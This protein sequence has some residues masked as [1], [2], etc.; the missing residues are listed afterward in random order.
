MDAS[1]GTPVVLTPH[2]VPQA[3]PR[4]PAFHPPDSSTAANPVVAN[5]N[6]VNNTIVLLDD[7][8][9]DDDD[10]VVVHVKVTK[11]LKPSRT[12]A[13]CQSTQTDGV[14]TSTADVIPL[15][16]DVVPLPAG[17]AVAGHD[18]K[19]KEEDDRQYKCPV[20]LESFSAVSFELSVSWSVI[21]EE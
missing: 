18:A 7:S 14:S 8:D 9:D 10:V 11:K 2:V 15:P 13:Y 5:N 1:T 12:P 3:A 6:N 19:K 16:A 20:C 21:R 4:L 17:G